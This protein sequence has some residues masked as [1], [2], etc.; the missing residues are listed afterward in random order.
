MQAIVLGKLADEGLGIGELLGH[1]FQ[2]LLAQEKHAVAI[3]KFA[4]VGNV[5]R[6]DDCFILPQFLADAFNHGRGLLWR[7]AFHQQKN[8]VH[9]LRERLFQL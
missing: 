5:N 1:V 6:F 2:F 7:I 8:G 9:I 4:F 3:K